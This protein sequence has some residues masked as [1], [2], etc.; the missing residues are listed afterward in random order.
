MQIVLLA[1]GN[2]SKLRPLTERFPS[3]MVPLVNRPVMSYVIEL[4]ARQGYKNILVC[5][6]SLA[7]SIESFFGDGKRWGVHL[8]YV[9]LS[10]NNGPAGTLKQVQHHLSDRFLVLPADIIISF[11]IEQSLHQHLEQGNLIT[12]ITREEQQ[13]SNPIHTGAYIVEAETLNFIPPRSKFDIEHD[14]FSKLDA[15]GRP[16][17]CHL[18]NDY[19][20]TLS[21]FL[22]H[23][24]AQVHLLQDPRSANHKILIQQNGHLNPGFVFSPTIN[25][26]KVTQGIWVGKNNFIHPS[27]R[28]TPPIY[29]GENNRIG[30]DVELGPATV[31]GSNNIIDDEATISNSTILNHT[32]IGQLV[33]LNRRVVDANLVIDIDTEEFTQISDAFLLGQTYQSLAD[34][35]ANHLLELLLLLCLLPV[36]L[37]VFCILSMLVWVANGNGQVFDLQ[38]M[39]KTGKE[40]EPGHEMD[41]FHRWNFRTNFR[42]GKSSKLISS[43]RRWQLYRLP[44]LINVF[45]GDMSLVGVSPKTPGQAAELT[46]EW[47]KKSLEYKS[48]FTGYWYV[49]TMANSTLDEMLVNDAYYVVTR[50]WRE[51]V[52]VLLQTPV[53]WIQKAR[54]NPPSRI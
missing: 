19:T 48:G 15:N 8:E 12:A 2:T 36:I 27:V 21:S 42:E 23:H 14:L 31:I 26:Q 30:R 41:T 38:I 34:S 9:L 52:H 4:V 54:V 7:G 13:V 49:K 46:E 24:K 50:T 40:K 5:L 33:H 10:Q 35:N 18:V 51:D 53:R 25:G 37:P 17:G 28:L 45:K 6:H 16:A 43:F 22:D 32:Y 3:P 29:I 20:N 1:T 44:E 11:D 39:Q 47:Q